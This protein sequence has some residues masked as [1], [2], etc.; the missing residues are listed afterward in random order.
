M[1]ICMVTSA[2]FPPE[3]GIGYYVYNLSKKLIE[4]GHKVTIITRGSINKSTQEVLDEID[5]IRGTFIPIYPFYIQIHGIFVNKIFKTLESEFDIVHIHSPLSPSIQ[6]SLPIIATI[7]TPTLTDTRS[8]EEKDFRAM[9]EKL[10][11]RFV[12][13]PI[14]L[15]LL[16]QA[17]IITAV[18]NSV[19]YELHEYGLNPNDVIVVGNG[20]DEEIFTP[21]INKTQ[22]RYIL[23]TGRLSHR[24]GL[25]DLIECGKYIC[26]KYPDVSFVIPGKGILLNKL[27]TQVEK[28]GLKDKFKFLGFVDRIKL[29]QLY[30][31]AAVYVMPSHYEG[32]PTVLLEAM[33]CGLPVVA[34][35]VSGNLDVLSS[36]ENGIL[37]PPKSPE[38]MAYA[39]SLLL[40]DESL[41]KKVGSNARKTIEEHYSWE[42]ITNKFLKCYQSL[43]RN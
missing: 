40:D 20:V 39:I 11:S 38:K 15:K 19:A 28:I 35:S 4:K 12:S 32:L 3:E 6:T 31:N 36:G 1:K 25:F 8:I 26:K 5:I 13:Y 16:K 10:M 9:I 23:Y 22:E 2:P 24:K 42:V 7:H 43:F 14:E 37:I 29:I 30:Q 34:T 27:K 21:M 17:D 18:A 41:R 33:S